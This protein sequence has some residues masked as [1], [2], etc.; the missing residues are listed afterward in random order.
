MEKKLEVVPVK[1]RTRQGCPLSLLLFNIVIKTLCV[2]LRKEKEIKG[3][4][5]EK[6]EI[7]LF[8]FA[9]YMIFYLRDIENFIRKQNN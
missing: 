8:L 2:A 5:I 7:K 1:S 3:I 9:E 6:E 4:Q